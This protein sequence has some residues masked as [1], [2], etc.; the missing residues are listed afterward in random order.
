MKHQ[1]IEEDKKG[2]AFQG[3]VGKLLKKMLIAINIKLE[4]VYIYHIQLILDPLKIE[5][6]PHKR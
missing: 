3:E 1:V 6:Q 2:L 4:N 5:N